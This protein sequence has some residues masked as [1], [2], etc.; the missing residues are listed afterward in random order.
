MTNNVIELNGVG[1]SYR[2]RPALQSVDF[3]LRPGHIC[4]LVGE[5]GA[6]K[7]TLIGII[8]GLIR[9]TEGAMALFGERD[10]RGIQRQR[11]RIG[12]MPDA[13]ALY[14]YMSARQNLEL[15][16]LEWGIDCSR[17]EVEG[18]LEEVG[19]SAA[20]RKK[21]RAFSLGMK[22]RL[23]VAV[24]LLGRPDLLVLDEPTNGLDPSGIV[25]VRRLLVGLNREHGTTILV[26][27]HVLSELREMASEYCFLSHG[28]VLERISSQELER[29]CGRRLV[30]CTDDAASALRLLSVSFPGIEVAQAAAAGEVH[31]YGD[32]DRASEMVGC[33]VGGG[34]AVSRFHVEEGSLEGY[35]MGLI[36]AG[37]R[38]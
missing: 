22:R 21:V 36:G 15:R 35:Y 16:C 23:S 6:G 26:S 12:Y 31:V 17:S 25:E 18:I 33:L 37:V 11:R 20:G 24:A 19:L 4:G 8:M 29:R 14:P 5:N 1:K 3:A 2:G 27:S 34:V 32:L 10:A 9:P 28:K 30:V 38:R 7:S 13:N